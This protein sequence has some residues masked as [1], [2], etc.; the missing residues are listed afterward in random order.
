MTVQHGTHVFVT[1]AEARRFDKAELYV[2]FGGPLVGLVLAIAGAGHLW[3]KK[4]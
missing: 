3:N 4:V 1:A 2:T